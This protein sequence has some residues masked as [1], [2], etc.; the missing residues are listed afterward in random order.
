VAQVEVKYNQISERCQ[1]DNPQLMV[2][3]PARSGP[4]ADRSGIQQT[5]ILRLF[6][7]RALRR[8]DEV[9]GGWDG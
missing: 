1:S 9:A 7:N 2:S 5:E 6:G 3:D 8:M 4:V